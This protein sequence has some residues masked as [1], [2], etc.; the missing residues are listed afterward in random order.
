M[1]LIKCPECGHEVSDGAPQCPYC[2]IPIAGNIVTCPDCGKVVLK[3]EQ[4]CPACGCHLSELATQTAPSGTSPSVPGT[5]GYRPKKNGGPGKWIWL[6]VALI[7]IAAAGFG[8]YFVN[9]QKQQEQMQEAYDALQNDNEIDDYEAFLTQYPNSPYSKVVKDRI[10]Q[11]KQ[12]RNRWVEISLSSSKGD[13]LQFLNQYPNSEYEQACKG[14]IDSL[15]WIEVSTENTLAAYQRYLD[16]HPDGKYSALA[17]ECKDNL[18]KVAVTPED[19]SAIRSVLHNY[20]DALTN[21]SQEDL[22]Q[23]VV[24]KMYDQSV[25]FMDKMHAGKSGASFTMQ[26]YP[27]ITKMPAA[28]AG[29]VF[30]AKFRAVRSET[31]AGGETKSTDYNVTTTLSDDYR[32]V[33]MKMQKAQTG[34]SAPAHE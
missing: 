6:V 34:D 11:L 23:L 16:E 21:N 30:V 31:E 19:K 33:S 22:A 25:L 14:K 29:M 17:M 1:A 15:D 8:Y 32:I 7:V 2:G 27:A 20:F 12:I 3:K 28:A 26:G 18:D 9:A 24:D 5:N 13:F 4:T 10:S